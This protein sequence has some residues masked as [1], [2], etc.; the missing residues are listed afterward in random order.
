MEE[1]AYYVLFLALFSRTRI[2]MF[3]V[4]H[5]SIEGLETTYQRKDIFDFTTLRGDYHI[6]TSWC[7]MNISKGPTFIGLSVLSASACNVSFVSKLSLQISLVNTL[8][9]YILLPI[10]NVS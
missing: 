3:N 7:Y 8:I 2:W 1:P 10:T 4:W 5:S 6:I 9:A